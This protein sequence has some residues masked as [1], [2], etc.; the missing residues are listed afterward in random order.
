LKNF[1]N[2]RILKKEQERKI[3]FTRDFGILNKELEASI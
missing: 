3:G 1:A 2:L